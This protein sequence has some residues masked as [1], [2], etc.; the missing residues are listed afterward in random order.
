M[1]Y[2]SYKLGITKKMET[3]INNPLAYLQKMET[4]NKTVNRFSLIDTVDWGFGLL[5]IVK[6]IRQSKLVVYCLVRMVSHV[7]CFLLAETFT[8]G[9]RSVQLVSHVLCL[10]RRV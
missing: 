3:W 2:N 9:H 6:P 5:I 1:E 10:P 7:L 8:T 4:E